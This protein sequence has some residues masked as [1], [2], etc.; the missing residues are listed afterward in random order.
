[1]HRTLEKSKKTRRAIKP[2]NVLAELS[3]VLNGVID[4][5]VSYDKVLDMKMQIDQAGP[6]SNIPLVVNLCLSKCPNIAICDI[7]RDRE[8]S[9]GRFIGPWLY[10]QPSFVLFLSL[11][12]LASSEVHGPVYADR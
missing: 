8:S 2:A 7:C 5:A 9:R 10:C 11:S 12:P 3:E 4:T 6:I 1:M